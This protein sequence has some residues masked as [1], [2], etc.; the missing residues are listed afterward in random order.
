MGSA[1]YRTVIVQ[2]R[3]KETG[4]NLEAGAPGSTALPPGVSWSLEMLMRGCGAG[5]V[6]GGRRQA[7]APQWLRLPPQ[8]L[9]SPSP[10]ARNT[11]PTPRQ[12][13]IP[14]P[15]PHQPPYLPKRQA[16]EA[17]VSSGS[18]LRILRSYPLHPGRHLSRSC[19]TPAPPLSPRADSPSV[20]AGL[21]YPGCLCFPD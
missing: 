4:G 16:A 18:P 10:C 1:P 15:R 17:L 14:T 21:K 3:R 19:L 5:S 6:G 13:P 2:K 20:T 8:W 12:S 11:H 9:L 7:E